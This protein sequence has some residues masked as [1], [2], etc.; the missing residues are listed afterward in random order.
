M[1]K[2][3]GYRRTD[4]RVSTRC[5]QA[6]WTTETVAALPKN[7]DY[8]SGMH[9]VTKARRTAKASGNDRMKSKIDPK[10]ATVPR[11]YSLDRPF[12]GHLYCT[13]A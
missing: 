7:P 6:K 10:L 4:A 8:V 12:N 3:Y 1:R 9:K 13:K 5:G 2:L 11:N